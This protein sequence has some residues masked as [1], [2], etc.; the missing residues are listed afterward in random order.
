MDSKTIKCILGGV[1]LAI[2]IVSAQAEEVTLRL[3]SAF[4]EDCVAM[5]QKTR[6]IFATQ[7]PSGRA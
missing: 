5:R 7:K 2:A 3:V 6:V 4:A 1:T